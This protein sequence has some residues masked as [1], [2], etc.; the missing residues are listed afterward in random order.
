MA[1]NSALLDRLQQVVRRRGYSRGTGRTYRVWCES[2]LRWLKRDRGEWTH[3]ETAGR[4]DVGRW[5]THLAVDTN[6]APTTQN[7][8]LQSVLFLYRECLGITI[9]DV[10]ALRA[11][12]PKQL[13]TI[14][15]PA[16]V[17]RLLQ[18]LNG[19]PLLLAKLMYGTGMRI[20]EAVSLR[21]KD[22]DFDNKQIMIRGAKGAKDR[23]AVL[24][25]MLTDPLLKQVDLAR[26][27]HSKDK[28]DGCCRVELPYAMARKSKWAAS[29]FIWFW[30]FPSRK[31]SKHPEEGWTGR[32][33]VNQSSIGRSISA[34]ALRA[35]IPKRVTPHCLRH[36]FATHML[37]TGT[38]IRTLQTLLG[39]ADVRTTMIYT[40]VET[41]GPSSEASPL[42][43]LDIA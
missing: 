16:E 1:L 34:A 35:K 42:D 28:K 27:Y 14:L 43:R 5:L 12:R 32:F 7:L 19:T 22:V 39:H 13:P 24:P 40:H 8:A 6:I 38:D 25:N 36:A 41:A 31:R 15:S 29:Q 11:K 30:V 23:I 4:D 3:P 21:I 18:N 2:Y 10:D 33:H 20:S 26:V 37:N 17:S 9:Q